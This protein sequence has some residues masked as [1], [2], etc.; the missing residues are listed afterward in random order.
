MLINIKSVLRAYILLLL[1][2]SFVCHA[3]SLITLSTYAGTPLS[4]PNQSGFYDLV[5]KEAFS[6]AGHKINIIQLP[7]ERSITNANEGITDGDFVRISGLTSIYKN[8]IQV[9][10]KITNFDFVAFSKDPT[11]KITDWQSAKP[12]HIGIVRGWKILEN[13]LAGAASLLRVKNQQLLF[14][15]LDKNRAN[16]VVYSRFEGYGV[17]RQQ[18]L[19][20]VHTLEP[21][22]AIREMYLYLNK[23]HAQLVPVISQHIKKR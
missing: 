23:Q 8:I 19:K 9:P 11:I 5:L 12:Y 2:I 10:E 17:I 16:I 6:R 15:L 7:A 13:N 21:P 22:M 18:N 14:K 3:E 4:T 1:T 20:G